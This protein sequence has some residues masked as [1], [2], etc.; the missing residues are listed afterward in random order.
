[1][2]VTKLS[3]VAIFFIASISMEA[4][5]QINYKDYRFG[6]FTDLSYNLHSADFLYTPDCPTCNPG[7]TSGSKMSYLNF[8]ALF[9]YKISKKLFLGLRV[10]YFSYNGNLRNQDTTTVLVNTKTPPD[11]TGHFEYGLNA[12]L[13]TIGFAPILTYNV[14]KSLNL[15]AGANIGVL[16]NKTQDVYEKIIDP[17]E[18]VF[19]DSHTKFRNVKNGVDIK[20]TNSVQA[21]LIFGASY[22]LPLN[23]DRTLIA[24]P[25]A[26]F[27]YALTSIIKDTA[28]SAHALKFGVAI[29]YNPIEEPEIRQEI[30]NQNKID[31]IRLV[32]DLYDNNT[33]KIG[34]NIVKTDEKLENY[35]KTI[36]NITFRTDTIFT[37]K[38]YA[39]DGD[40]VAFGLD[41]AG[42]E[43]PN[44]K[45]TIEEF[46]ASKLHPLLNYIFFDENSAAIPEKY[47]ALT[48]SDISTFDINK[49]YTL[50][51]MSIY[52]YILNIVGKRL[53]DN[54]TANLRIVGCIND[55][56]Q[57]KSNKELSKSRAEAV[58]NYFLNIWGINES[59]LK[60][61]VKGLPEKASTP[62]D[63]P[64]KMQENQRVEL[65]SD[66]DVV[67]EPVFV[68]DTLRVSNP[69]SL[70]FKTNVR[71][72]AGFS[73]GKI[74]IKQNQM[75]YKNFSVS[76][77]GSAAYEWKLDQANMPRLNQVLEY[78]LMF[79]DKKGQIAAPIS[80]NIFLEQITIKKKRLNILKDKEIEKFSLI[81]FNFD[82]A[83]ISS[84]NSKIVD[85]IK[86]RF[87]TNT[88]ITITGFTDRTGDETYNKNLSQRRAE[89]TFKA[90]GNKNAS[91]I[92][93]GEEQ[94]IYDNNNPEGRFYCRTVE[95][96]L[97]TDINY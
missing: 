36:T 20:G 44:P 24:V 88:Q 48:K 6:V 79:S 64:E 84:K 56:N 65:Y 28:W 50:E 43:I 2:R 8:G 66:N 3:L 23:R 41:S 80:K 63:D 94:L 4:Q 27:Y 96:L 7:F 71:T 26:F 33:F 61:E 93:R 74:E 92:G 59:R 19:T 53:T 89:A 83:D 39:L 13:S 77:D 31:T 11:V 76:S 85:F 10:G 32:S 60:I 34:T 70:R 46:S 42:N 86:S 40:I 90:L 57:E 52:Y 87:K 9:D 95:I 1:M 30:K 16:I 49:L 15:H 91:Y 29:M 54:P 78:G 45:M 18:A 17:A 68:A 25:E 12:Y 47:K 38:K 97:E 14:Y 58:K 5:N 22:E 75:I 82:K 72:E 37:K 62:T 73:N 69:P 35:I 51:T 67:L 21:H 81:L 55:R